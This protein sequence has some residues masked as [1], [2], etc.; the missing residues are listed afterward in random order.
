MET[1]I[2]RSPTRVDL[3][4][5][6]LDMWP[7]YSF[8]G[9]VVTLNFAIDIYTEAR[10][11]PREDQKVHLISKDVDLDHCFENL[12]ELLD[13]ADSRLSLFQPVLGY[14]AEKF[15]LSKGF[16]LTTSSQSP[17]GGGLGGS[18][19]LMISLLK[20]MGQFCNQ[21]WDVYSLIRLASNMEAH[22]LSTP[23][24]TQDYFPAVSG[25]LN[26][27][28]YDMDGVK[29]EVLDLDMTELATHLVLVYTGRPH[30]SGLNN[31]DV[32]QS[33]V[34]GKQKTIEALE[35]LAQVAKSMESVCRQGRWSELPSLFQQEYRWRRELSSA[36]TSPEIE[37]LHELS[38]A[39]GAEA[40]KICGAGGGGCVLLY[41]SPKKRESVIQGCE[42]EGFTVL[43]AQPVGV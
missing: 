30:H 11:T 6:T 23:T 38:L 31:W 5:G 4:G 3:A 35:N 29:Q 34:Q 8:L 12:K 1:I 33:V 15:S 22:L 24:G 7:L 21:S 2:S 43:Q 17:V 32:L 19:S 9:N 39:L 10:L 20:V 42:K 40:L 36:F 37:K 14:F 41:V 18:S 25:G 28:R 27:L 13:S 16:T 26:V